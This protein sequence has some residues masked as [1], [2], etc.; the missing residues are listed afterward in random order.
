MRSNVS[1]ADLRAPVAP[2]VLDLSKSQLVPRRVR[3]K[4]VNLPVSR[5]TLSDHC[6]GPRT[7]RDED[8]SRVSIRQTRIVRPAPA[9]ASDTPS[10]FPPSDPL[11]NAHSAFRA[12]WQTTSVLIHENGRENASFGRR[13][14]STGY[15]GIFAPALTQVGARGWQA[16]GLRVLAGGWRLVPGAARYPEMA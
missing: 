5:P 7:L 9:S 12:G 13:L 10:S 11:P 14:F 8:G 3:S 4:A 1:R 16:G 15:M 2:R 6:A